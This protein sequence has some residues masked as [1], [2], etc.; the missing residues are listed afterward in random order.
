MTIACGS[1]VV[2]CDMPIRLDTYTGCTH[3]CSYCFARRNRE[4]EKVNPE[5]SLVSLRRFI[6]GERTQQ[7]NWCDWRIPLH[8]GGMSD[9][10]QP[11]EAEGKASLAVLEEL[12]KTQY[13]VVISTKGRLIVEEPYLGLLAQANV[14]LQI[15]LVH[16][17][18]DAQ[19][20]GAPTAEERVRW[21]PILAPKVKRLLVRCQPYVPGLAGGIIKDFLPRYRDAGVHGVTFEGFKGLKAFPGSEKVLGDN[22]FSVGVLKPDFLKLRDGCHANKLAFYSAENRLRSLGDSPNCCGTDG[23]PGF[24]GNSANLNHRAADGSLIYTPA[25]KE[26]GTAQSFRTLWQTSVGGLTLATKSYAEVMELVRKTDTFRDAV[27]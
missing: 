23:V 16:A 13:P 25:M 1:Q 14:V 4:I 15:S 10:F 6:N 9:G 18:L 17:E 20:K 24:Q 19:E 22:V 12:V 3:N 5:A 11:R 21:L 8:W 26:V 7:T 2:L 27:K